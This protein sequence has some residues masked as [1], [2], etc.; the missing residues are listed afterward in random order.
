[1]ARNWQALL[2]DA[3]QW[4]KTNLFA[5]PLDAALTVIALGVLALVLPPAIDWAFIEARWAGA[6]REACVPEGAC[7]VFIKAR[8]GQ[9]AYGFYPMAERWRVDLVAAL[10]VAI[11]IF[12]YFAPRPRRTKLSAVLGASY[13]LIAFWLLVGGALGLDLVGTEKWGGLMLTLV[14]TIVGLAAAFPFGVLLALGR[15]SEKPVIRTLSIV[16]IEFWRGVPL[17]TVLFMASVMLP[18]FLPEGVS[19]DKLL[20][21]LVGVALFTAAYMAEV[22]RGGLQAIP[23]GQ[24]EAAHALGLG[25][26]KTHALVVLP[27]ALRVVI[28]GLVNVFIAL[29]KDT[30]LVLIVGLFDLLG[31]IQAALADPAWL[32]FALEGYVFAAIVFWVLCFTLS[33]ASL[34]LEKRLAQGERR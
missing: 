4:L 29:L 33:R 18:L 1:M 7:W 16:Y 26:W 12:L 8:L 15:R 19:L 2:P 34:G 32:G 21:A 28:P 25:Y 5:T 20:R 6:A 9:F 31:I 10:A 11:G 3:Y 24:I 17:V 22:V 14:V 30:T 13:F 27:Q 23:R